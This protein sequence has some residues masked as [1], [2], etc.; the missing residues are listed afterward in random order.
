MRFD[1]KEGIRRIWLD[2]PTDQTK[3]FFGKFNKI[4]KKIKT[5]KI[6]LEKDKFVLIYGIL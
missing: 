4:I 2:P 5:T 1:F 3:F 6:V